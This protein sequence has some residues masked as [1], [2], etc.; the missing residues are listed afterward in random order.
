MASVKRAR[1]IR[2]LCSWGRSTQVLLELACELVVLLSSLVCR[3]CFDSRTK[4]L[5]VALASGFD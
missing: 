5:L 3:H 4:K 2:G 1:N